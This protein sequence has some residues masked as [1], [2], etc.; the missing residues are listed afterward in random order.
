MEAKFRC[1]SCTHIFNQRQAICEDWRVPEKS[2]ICPVCKSYLAVKFSKGQK[3]ILG[4]GVTS[5][6]IGIIVRA[7]GFWNISLLV[8]FVPIFLLLVYGWRYGTPFGPAKTK[9]VREE[10]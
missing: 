2:L 9:I 10:N 8:M 5:L 1:C 4:L 3:W 7:S 6:I